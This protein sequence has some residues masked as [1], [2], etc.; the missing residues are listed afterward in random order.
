[1]RK[2]EFNGQIISIFSSAK[3]LEKYHNMNCSNK[4]RVTNFLIR[5]IHKTNWYKLQMISLGLGMFINRYNYNIHLFSN[6]YITN[7]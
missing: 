7:D 2:L 6:A 5:F 4:K 3:R 1:M